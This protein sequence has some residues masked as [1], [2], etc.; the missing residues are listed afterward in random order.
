VGTSKFQAVTRSIS[1]DATVMIVVTQTI[2]IVIFRSNHVCSNHVCSSLI[3]VLS[4]KYMPIPL[5]VVSKPA[6]QYGWGGAKVH[7][8]TGSKYKW[9]AASRQ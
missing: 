5:T 9:P 3:L 8:G 4:M 6:N 7:P 1:T 2:I